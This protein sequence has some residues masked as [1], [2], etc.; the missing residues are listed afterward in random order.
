MYSE[1]HPENRQVWLMT[2]D[3]KI[4]LLNDSG[5]P[6]KL[7]KQAH[8]LRMRPSPKSIDQLAEKAAL[9]LKADTTLIEI[10]QPALQVST[11]SVFMQRV[12]EGRFHAKP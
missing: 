7:I 3:K 10:W 8:Q 6:A 1:V 11:N 4:N 9:L 12:G 2:G 5:V